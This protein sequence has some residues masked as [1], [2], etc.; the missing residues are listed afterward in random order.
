M[1]RLAF[2]TF[3]RFSSFCQYN[4]G[5]LTDAKH[6]TSTNVELCLQSDGYKDLDA[7]LQLAV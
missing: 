2:S 7:S 1:P 4:F 5:I 3:K 6:S